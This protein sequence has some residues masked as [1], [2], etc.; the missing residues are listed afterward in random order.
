MMP[1]IERIVHTLPHPEMATAPWA[2]LV[3]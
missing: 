3:T 1:T 2:A